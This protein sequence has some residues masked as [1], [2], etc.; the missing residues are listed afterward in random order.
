MLTGIK[1]KPEQEQITKEW[2]QSIGAVVG[3]SAWKNVAM[4]ITSP[5]VMFHDEQ[6]LVGFT[7]VPSIKTR[8]QVLSL[9]DLFGH[10][11]AD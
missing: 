9:L 8:L 10:K 7:P 5:P 1:M 4:F 3:S 2:C 6:I 11:R